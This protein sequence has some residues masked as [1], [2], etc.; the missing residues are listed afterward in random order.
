MMRLFVGLGLPEALTAQ[1]APLMT[2]LPGA[3]WVAAE[4]LHLTL[5]FIGEVDEHQAAI[6]DESLGQIRRPAFALQVSGCG[7]FA[8]RRGPEAVWVGVGSSPALTELQAA[9]ERAAVRAGEAPEEKRFR[10]HITL[11][12]LRDTPAPRLQAFV[13]GHNLFRATAAVDRF[14]LY[15]S[16]SGSGPRYRIETSYPLDGSGLGV[17]T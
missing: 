8:Q 17:D 3:R 9:V 11:A 14:N 2:G 1:L 15:S 16:S 5:R 6:L 7:I 12:R 13:A 10:P 4:D